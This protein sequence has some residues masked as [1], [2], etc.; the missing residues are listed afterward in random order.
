MRISLGTAVP[1]GLQGTISLCQ[2]QAISTDITRRVDRESLGHS[3]SGNSNSD[4]ETLRE[5][6][7]CKSRSS[8]RRDSNGITLLYFSSEKN[9]SRIVTAGDAVSSNEG[10]GSRIST[11]IRSHRGSVTDTTGVRKLQFADT[12]RTLTD[13]LI[14]GQD[15]LTRNRSFICIL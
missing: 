4:T 1:N 3:A 7:G 14:F 6:G 13:R 15:L 9:D 12:V 8:N 10:V 11:V 2:H 5:T